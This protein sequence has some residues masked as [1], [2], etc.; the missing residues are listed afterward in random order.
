MKNI[1][2]LVTT[3][4]CA[5]SALQHLKTRRGKNFSYKNPRTL[6]RAAPLSMFSLRPSLIY[7]RHDL[8]PFLNIHESLRARSAIQNVIYMRKHGRWLRAAILDSHIPHTLYYN[9]LSAFSHHCIF[10]SNPLNAGCALKQ[11]TPRERVFGR[12]TP[13]TFSFSVCVC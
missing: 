8:Q 7:S 2:C 12:P 3:T 9:I 5:P 6:H 13:L 10:N 1:A 11:S 4:N